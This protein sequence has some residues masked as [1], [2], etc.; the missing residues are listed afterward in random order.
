MYG[1]SRTEVLVCLRVALNLRLCH[2]TAPVASRDVSQ[3]ANK[4]PIHT[5]DK[6]ITGKYEAFVWSIVHIL[7]RA[8]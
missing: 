7:T 3:I 4:L 1:V 2:R 6:D 5:C 8:H